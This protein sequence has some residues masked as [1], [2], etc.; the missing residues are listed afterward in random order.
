MPYSQT[1]AQGLRVGSMTLFISVVVTAVIVAVVAVAA[2][3]AIAVGIT[4][5]TAVATWF[6]TAVLV[7]RIA[8]GLYGAIVGYNQVINGNSYVDFNWQNP[9]GGFI[10][11]DCGG[12]PE[13]WGCP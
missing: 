7:G 6:G 4:T 9:N 1:M 8:G 11:W 2:G 5:Y 13:V 10:D 3:A 12:N